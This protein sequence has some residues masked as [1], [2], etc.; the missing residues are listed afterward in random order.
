MNSSRSIGLGIAAAVVAILVLMPAVV[1]A[2]FYT[3]AN[4]HAIVTGWDFSSDTMNVPAFVTGLVLTVATVV[5]LMGVVVGL[6]GRSLSPKRRREDE[7][8]DMDVAEVPE[9]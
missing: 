4:V 6:I 1:V 3:F 2:L 8:F 9:P 5:V 7:P